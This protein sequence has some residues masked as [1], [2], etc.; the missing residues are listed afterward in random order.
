MRGCQP[1]QTG[2][3]AES[4]G[5]HTDNV[6]AQGYPEGTGWKILVLIPK[7]NTDTRCIGLMESLCKVVGEIINTCLREIVYIH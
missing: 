6:E 2:A 3:V 1:P 5:Y 7:G 4:G